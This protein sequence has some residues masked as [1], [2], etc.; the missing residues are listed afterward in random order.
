MRGGVFWGGIVSTRKA[1]RQA[2]WVGYQRLFI[3][4]GR[5]FSVAMYKDGRI[6]QRGMTTGFDGDGAGFRLTGRSVSAAQAT[7]SLRSLH[8]KHSEAMKAANEAALKAAQWSRHE[9]PRN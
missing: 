6:E 1:K 3:V 8:A 2:Y 7:A 9:L 5:F 4:V